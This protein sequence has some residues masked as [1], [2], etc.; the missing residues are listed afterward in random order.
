MRI[1]IVANGIYLYRRVVAIW[2]DG[3]ALRVQHHGDHIDV[4]QM[5]HVR[6]IERLDDDTPVAGW[7]Q[8]RLT[9]HSL[10]EAA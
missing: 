4:L 1:H 9:D 6:E 10:Q 8:Q 5:C 2:S 7:A 3:I